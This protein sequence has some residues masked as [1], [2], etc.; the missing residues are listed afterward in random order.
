MVQFVHFEEQNIVLIT[1]SMVL[2]L[3]L[4]FYHREC[5][6]EYYKYGKT[7]NFNIALKAYASIKIY[8][9]HFKLAFNK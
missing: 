1:G 2:T 7:I 6:S 5:K 9:L 8:L 4:S 3:T